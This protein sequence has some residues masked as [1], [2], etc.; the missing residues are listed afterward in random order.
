MNNWPFTSSRVIFFCFLFSFLTTVQAQPADD[1]FEEIKAYDFDQ[2]QKI[3]VALE[4]LVL[5]SNLTIEQKKDLAHRL[6]GLLD[7]DASYACKQFI[8]RNLAIIGSADEVPLLCEWLYDDRMSDMARYALERIPD[9]SA[10]ACLREALNGTS[11]NKQI[12][13][14]TTIGMR[15]DKQA[16][17][18][19]DKLLYSENP[20]VS[21]SAAWALGRIGG[22]TAAASLTRALSVNTESDSYGELADAYLECAGSFLQQGNVQSALRIYRRKCF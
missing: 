12:G 8:C 14:I 4:E 1:W 13:I 16:V 2:D 15:A 11:G 22:G 9:S 17:I 7:S 3:L 6:A 10:D 20:E 5:G 19:L 18:Q 21:E